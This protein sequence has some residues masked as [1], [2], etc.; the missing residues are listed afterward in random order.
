MKD[1][2]TGERADFLKGVQRLVVKIG[3]SLISSKNHGLDEKRLDAYT[4]EV[5]R[6]FPGRLWRIFGPRNCAKTRSKNATV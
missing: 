1:K 2:M 5:A 4:E 3:S 6:L